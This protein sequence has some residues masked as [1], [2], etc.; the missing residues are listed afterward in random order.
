VLVL[1]NSKNKQTGNPLFQ[2]IREV[3]MASSFAYF[4]P[5]VFYVLFLYLLILFFYLVIRRR[6]IKHRLYDRLPQQ[7]DGAPPIDLQHPY[8]FQYTTKVEDIINPIFGANYRLVLLMTRLVSSIY[9]VVAIIAIVATTERAYSW[10]YFDL[11][12]LLIVTIYFVLTT[13]LTF[14]SYRNPP[15]TRTQT[16]TARRWSFLSKIMSVSVHMLFEVSSVITLMILFSDWMNWSLKDE[17]VNASTYLAFLTLLIEL[18]INS[19]SIRFDQFPCIL[20]L[21][22][23]YF[24]VLWPAAFNGYLTR[25]PYSFL[26]LDTYQCFGSYTLIFIAAWISSLIWYVVFKSKN[27]LVEYQQ[28]RMLE[29]ADLASIQLATVVTNEIEDDFDRNSVM[30]GGSSSASNYNNNSMYPPLPPHPYGGYMPNNPYLPGRPP[31]HMGPMPMLPPPP[32]FSVAGGHYP[33]PLP[34]NM[35]GPPPP[36]GA[37]FDPMYNPYVR[38][39]P[40]GGGPPYMES[41]VYGAGYPQPYPAMQS[42]YPD[43]MQFSNHYLHQSY[44]PLQQPPAA[45]YGMPPQYAPQ[46]SDYENFP[47]A[48]SNITPEE[49]QQASSDPTYVNT[50]RNQFLSEDR[51]PSAL[52]VDDKKSEGVSS[53]EVNASP[54]AAGGLRSGL[55]RGSKSNTSGSGRVSFGADEVFGDNGSGAAA[56]VAIMEEHKA[57]NAEEDLSAIKDA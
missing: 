36:G 55:K 9:F 56:G 10:L 54:T 40:G 43:P 8:H 19:I 28:A 25:W 32:L 50:L 27:T 3:T 5:L 35:T 20:S 31:P 46:E 47:D 14:M 41:S 38:G 15:T 37:G 12:N 42:S 2:I 51:K 30:S 11:W 45:P 4:T 13:A 53:P 29:R 49:F 24:F 57:S 33:G 6:E 34:T 44:S 17:F 16:N 26:A 23:V 48:T 21:I 22:M 52:E 18:L 1:R 7:E 39:A